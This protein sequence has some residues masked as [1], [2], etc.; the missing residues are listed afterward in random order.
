M[1]ILTTA[2]GAMVGGIWKI[3]AIA[4]AVLSLALCA[5]LGHGWYMAA[6]DRDQAIVD[7]KAEREISAQ[8]QTAIREQNN[9]VEALAEQKRG[10]EQRGKV[11][12]DLAV[13]NGRRYDDAVARNR[14]AT[15]N[16]C[17]EAMPVVNDI[18]EAIR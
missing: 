5:F 17:D 16:T 13:A 3:G 8:Y 18:L 4:L 10:A 11:A 14:A 7:L 15:A 2:A 1:N 12:L 6:H 9:A